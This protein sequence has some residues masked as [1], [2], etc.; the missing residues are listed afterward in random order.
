MN[1]DKLSTGGA[2]PLVNETA[3]WQAKIDAVS[4]A[5]G[6]KVVVPAGT[7]PVA[8]LELKSN[9]TL[10]LAE[11]ATLSAVSDYTLYRWQKDVKAE[12][13]RTGVL[14]AYGAT[15]IAVVG[16]GTIDGGGDREPKTTKRPTRLRNIYFEDCRGVEIRGVRM[17]NPRIR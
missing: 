9:V 6:G 5:G 10:E 2:S 1:T 3:E 4:A 16:K 17:E 8:E 13:Q 11:G 14:V 12:L 15:N 7:H